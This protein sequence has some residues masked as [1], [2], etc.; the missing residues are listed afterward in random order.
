MRLIK[1]GKMPIIR[2]VVTSCNCCHCEF[3]YE[4]NDI[5]PRGFPAF[6]WFVR[7]PCCGNNVTVPKHIT[8]ELEANRYVPLREKL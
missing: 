4:E 5:E 6:S 1:E 7:C 3:S 8:R 2:E